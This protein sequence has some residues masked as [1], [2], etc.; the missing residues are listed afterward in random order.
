M[1]TP[2]PLVTVGIPAYDR[3]DGLRRAIEC[4][5][6]QTLRDLEVI[7]SDDASPTDLAPVVRPHAERD[8]RLRFV[9]QPANLGPEGNHLWLRDQARG[10][11]FVWLSD[12]DWLD[13]TFLEKAVRVLETD[14]SVAMCFC[15]YL[16]AEEDGKVV[17][18]RT[19]RHLHPDA[20]W[21]EGQLDFFRYPYDVAAN[22]VSGVYRLDVLRRV[23]H[24]FS[25]TFR[26]IM[27]GHEAPLLAQMARRGRILVLP[28]ALFIRTQHSRSGDSLAHR[29][30]SGLRLWELVL[31]YVTIETKLLYHALRAEVPVRQ[32]LRLVRTALGAALRKA[33]T[34]PS[35]L[36]RRLVRS[37][38]S[39][40][41]E[42]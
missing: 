42:P 5:L 20:P 4:A 21:S 31:L 11:Y 16:Y 26:R 15:D 41:P 40:S 1:P 8:P 14:A 19:L 30:S 9:R 29:V 33:A 7:V 12:D 13:P 35:A 32:R 2:H 39:R 25:N 18:S 36:V 6:S 38:P 23:R 27:S 28:E 10:K 24:P 3:P 22:I 34:A 37:P 17:G